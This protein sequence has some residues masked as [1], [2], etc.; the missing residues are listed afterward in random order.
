[1][2]DGPW[3]QGEVLQEPRVELENGLNGTKENP[4]SVPTVRW[5]VGK[6]GGELERNAAHAERPLQKGWR[7]K[8]P[9]AQCAHGAPYRQVLISLTW[10]ARR[11]ARPPRAWPE[12]DR[13][14]LGSHSCPCRRNPVHLFQAVLD[15]GD[16]RAG[17]FLIELA[18]RRA[19]DADCADRG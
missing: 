15:L 4:T 18:T 5:K 7:G 3:R 13:P 17:A 11:E 8:L 1:A 9:P 19:A 12:P 16:G 6:A 14:G 2:N 10:G